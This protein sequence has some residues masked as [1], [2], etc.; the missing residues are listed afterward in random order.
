MPF[1]KFKPKTHGPKYYKKKAYSSKRKYS[2]RRPSSKAKYIRKVS[3]AIKPYAE[4]KKQLGTDVVNAVP[5]VT[6][7]Y[8]SGPIPLLSNVYTLGFDFSNAPTS[9]DAQYGGALNCTVLR[10]GT[11]SNERIGNYI[12]AKAISGS[13]RIAMNAV[14]TSA[15]PWVKQPVMFKCYWFRSNRSGSPTGTVHSPNSK[16]FI[17]PAG[18]GSGPA[19][20]DN[21]GPGPAQDMSLLNFYTAPVNRKHFT[22]LKKAQFTLG[23]PA[24][25]GDAGHHLANTQSNA[26]LPSHKIVSFRIPLGTKVKYN[27]TN[28]AQDKDLNIRLMVLAMPTGGVTNYAAS[29]WTM[30]MNSVMN[31]TDM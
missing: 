19:A 10:Q 15:E 27:E 4:T 25:Y 21:S 26:S 18:T 14:T 6:W 2:N 28:T 13:F 20:Q 1:R 30:S 16:F 31:Y 22:L 17:K 8:T 29:N 24:V 3:R 12:I 7:S 23:P 11:S 9:V 5:V